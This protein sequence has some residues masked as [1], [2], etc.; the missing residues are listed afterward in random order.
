[1]HRFFD[2]NPVLKWLQFGDGHSW[3]AFRP[4]GANPLSLTVGADTYTMTLG[5]NADRDLNVSATVSGK[6]VP[7]AFP[8]RRVASSLQILGEPA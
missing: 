1:M 3:E 5:G 7:V 4:T 8:Y 2:G 6:P